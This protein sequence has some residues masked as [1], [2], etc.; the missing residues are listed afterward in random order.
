MKAAMST[1]WQ[2][3]S[4]HGQERMRVYENL[5]DKLDLLNRR[6]L[7]KRFAGELLQQDDGLQFEYQQIYASNRKLSLRTFTSDVEPF[8]MKTGRKYRFERVAQ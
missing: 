5:P 8:D 4:V 1:I 7:I 2:I 6:F 3:E